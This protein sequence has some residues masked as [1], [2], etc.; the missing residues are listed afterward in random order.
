MRSTKARRGAAAF[1]VVLSTSIVL[2]ACGGSSGGSGS[3]GSAG[4]KAPGLNKAECAPIKS[5]LTEYGDLSGKH[6]KVYTSVVAPEDVPQKNSYKL[7]ESC[8]GATVD[9]E[10]SKEFEAQLVVR[11]KS[12]NPPDIA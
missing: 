4:G 1:A 8:S 2:A 6:V 12:G 10:G 7:F 3:S 9:Y 5:I 11:V